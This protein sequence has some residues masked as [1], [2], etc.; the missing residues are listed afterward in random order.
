MIVGKIGIFLI[1]ILIKL[2]SLFRKNKTNKQTNKNKTV[3]ENTCL[4]LDYKVTP[5]KLQR[6]SDK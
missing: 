3:S 1:K 4:M 6:I 5:Q 2:Y